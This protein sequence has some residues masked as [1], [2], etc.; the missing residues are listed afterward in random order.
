M[1]G[2]A[3]RVGGR[4]VREGAVVAT[5]LDS[6]VLDGKTVFTGVTAIGVTVGTAVGFGLQ[7]PSSTAALAA[8]AITSSSTTENAPPPKLGGSGST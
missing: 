5:G 8:I 6:G 4:G 7:T 1:I 2:V 3:V